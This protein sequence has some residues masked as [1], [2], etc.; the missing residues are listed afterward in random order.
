MLWQ[1]VHCIHLCWTWKEDSMV[2]MEVTAGTD[3]CTID[4]CRWYK[5]DPRWCNEHK[6]EVCHTSVWQNLHQGGP[7]K[8]EA[9]STKTLSATNPAYPSC[10]RGA[11]QESS[12]PGWS[13][14][15]E[16]TATRPCVAITNWLGVGE[17]RRAPLNYIATSIKS[18]PQADLLWVQEW[19]QKALQM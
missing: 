12:L 18:M 13:H 3:I 5:G 19:L 6:R 8:K 10:S 17:D 16:D 2:N 4:A 7:C 9:L 14:L 15:G 1:A 11:C